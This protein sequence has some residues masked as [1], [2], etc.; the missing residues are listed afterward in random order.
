MWYM[1]GFSE[2]TAGTDGRVTGI[3]RWREEGGGRRAK[4]A[5]LK[6]TCRTYIRYAKEVSLWQ[7]DYDIVDHHF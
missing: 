1:W 6:Y 5:G 7:T 4:K 2:K 3:Y